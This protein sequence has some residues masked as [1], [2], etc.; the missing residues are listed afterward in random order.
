MRLA[1]IDTPE[2]KQ[3]F[4]VKAR[5]ALCKRI[6]GKLVVVEY[7]KRDR[8]GQIIGTVYLDR[9]NINH[10]MIRDGFAW[11][12]RKYSKDNNLRELET[13]A[14][15]RTHGLGSARNPIPPWDYGKR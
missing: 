9:R 10:D 6:L 1:E 12:Y 7:S 3:A 8:Y 11:W 2:K 5:Q 4:G 15:Q 14:R 13:N